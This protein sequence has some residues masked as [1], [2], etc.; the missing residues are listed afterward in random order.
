LIT[1][2]GKRNMTYHVQGK[3]SPTNLEAV[4]EDTR[5]LIRRAAIRH[6]LTLAITDIHRGVIRIDGI[7]GVFGNLGSHTFMRALDN[8]VQ[9]QTLADLGLQGNLVMTKENNEGSS[10]SPVSVREGRVFHQHTFDSGETREVALL[11]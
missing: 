6:S 2:L 5:H 4:N 3:L 11:R 10:P 1:T 8:F 9:D 7:F